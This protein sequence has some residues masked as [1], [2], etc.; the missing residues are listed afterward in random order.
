MTEKEKI[1]SLE[2]LEKLSQNLTE[3]LFKQQIQIKN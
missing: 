1:I 2:C 3:I